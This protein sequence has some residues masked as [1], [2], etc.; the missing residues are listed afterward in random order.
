MRAEPQP[1]AWAL[2]IAY[3]STTSPPVTATAPAMSNERCA[4]VGADS[5]M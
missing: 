2:T 5:G 1:K 3:T 4:T